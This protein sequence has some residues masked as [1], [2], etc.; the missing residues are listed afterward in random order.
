MK[1]TKITAVATLGLLLAACSAGGGNGAPQEDAAKTVKIGVV[2]SSTGGAAGMGELE[3]RGV[4]LYEKLHGEEQNLEFIYA[5]DKSDPGAAVSAVNK[6]IAE[7]Q[8]DAVICCTTTPASLAVREP[9]ELAETMQVSV[10]AGADIVEPA[11]ER[12]YSFKTPYTDRAVQT[13]AVADMKA[14]GVKSVA[15]LYLD[16]AYGEGGKAAL[17]A[18]AADAGIDVVASAAFARD[19]TDVTAQ[20]LSLKKENPDAYVVWAILPSA[21]VAQKALVDNG[22]A[23]PV[24]HSFGVTAPAF[25][26]LGGDSVEGVRI[27]AGR[28]VAHQDVE[29]EDASSQAIKEFAEAYQ[30][31]FGESVTALSGFAY[32]AAGLIAQAASDTPAENGS[33]YRVA[34]RNSFEK[35]S[36]YVGTTGTFTYSPKDHTGIDHASLGV[37][38]V[39]DGKFTSISQ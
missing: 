29:G 27:A 35:I 14:N 22:V 20:V 39:K 23:E 19:A 31:E 7:D 37:V 24:Y 2:L 34:L 28:L 1:K 5:D 26:D 6:M 32:D 25:M 10:A 3:R 30:E 11:A 38:V 9:L 4:E 33:A 12:V 21:N 17:E 18:A 36:G 16:D 8:V 15:V 13:A